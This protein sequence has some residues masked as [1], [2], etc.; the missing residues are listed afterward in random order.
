MKIQILEKDEN[1]IKFVLEGVTPS[2]ANELRRIMMVETP[3]MA[4][5]WVDFRKNDSILNDEIM[6]N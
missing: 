3:T 4:I 6:A 2:F 5:E 1:N